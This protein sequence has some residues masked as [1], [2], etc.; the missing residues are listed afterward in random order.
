MAMRRNQCRARRWCPRRRLSKW[1]GVI[2]R[3]PPVAGW[4]LKSARQCRPFGPEPLQPLLPYYERLRPCA[5]PRYSPTHGGCPLVALPSQRSDRF[6]TEAQCTVTPPLC[7]TP[8]GQYTGSPHTAPGIT[9][10]PPVLTSSRALRHVL[11]GSLPLVS[12]L[13]T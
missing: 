13:F 4:P 9:R 1:L 8:C 12:V 6:P 11:S 10:L 7:R 2:H 5:P 3:A